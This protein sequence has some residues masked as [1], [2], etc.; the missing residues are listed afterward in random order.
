MLSCNRCRNSH[1]AM[2]S[3]DISLLY[4]HRITVTQMDGIHMDLLISTRQHP[5]SKP[6]A[7]RIQVIALQ[8]H[9][10]NDRHC[11][12]AITVNA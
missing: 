11:S 8:S 3:S 1:A 6:I 12:P 7:N 4:K 2:S 9:G 10:C 5:Q